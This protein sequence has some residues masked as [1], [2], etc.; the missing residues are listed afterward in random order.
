MSSSDRCNALV[1]R[2]QSMAAQLSYNVI[3]TVTRIVPLALSHILFSIA[4]KFLANLKK[5]HLN[6]ET[7]NIGTCN[8]FNSIDCST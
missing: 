2:L 1:T 4:L 8:S 6:I 3:S 5:F 7:F